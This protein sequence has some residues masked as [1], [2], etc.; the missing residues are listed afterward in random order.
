MKELVSV[1]GLGV[2]S[3]IGRGVTET[4]DHFTRQQTGIGTSTHLQ[5]IHTLPVGEVKFTNLELQEI[6]E[7]RK[8]LPRT[9]MLGMVAVRDA[10]SSCSL[11]FKKYR[12]GLISATTVGGM[13]CTENFFIDF[14]RD[15]TSGDINSIRYH[16]CGKTTQLIAEVMGEVEFISTINTACSSSV[17]AIIYA[18]RLIAHGHLDVVIAGTEN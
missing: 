16:E 6:A 8:A 11:D 18:A 10:I 5:S 13:D 17:N 9:A 2:I 14:L 15:E 1:A 4:L 7:T 3:A 12:T